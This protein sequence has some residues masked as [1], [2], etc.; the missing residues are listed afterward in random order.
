[1]V[2]LS[3]EPVPVGSTRHHHPG[4]RCRDRCRVYTPEGDGP[5]PGVVFFHGGGWVI[6]SLDTH[7]N[8]A[9]TICRDADS[10]VVS[11]D[12][13]MAPEFR[14]PT[15][16]SL[17]RSDQVGGRQRRSVERRRQQACAVR[18]QCRRQPQA[19]VSQMARQRRTGHRVHGIDLPGRRHDLKGGSLDEN[20]TGSSWRSRD[21]LVHEPLPHR[22]RES[23]RW[24]RRCCT[25]TCRAAGLLHRDLR[26]RPL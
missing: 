24:P 17:F 11:V 15:A 3:G 23:K 8:I 14:Y 13:R 1:M 22:H 20:A 19:V 9:R 6:C 10:V 26:V 4:R 25:T 21:G 2:A 18:R 16:A 5:Y 7:D 12:Y